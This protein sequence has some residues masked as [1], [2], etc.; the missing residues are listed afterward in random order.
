MA[1]P[2]CPSRYIIYLRLK[3]FASYKGGIFQGC[4]GDKKQEATDCQAVAAVGW[5]RHLIDA[6]VSPPAVAGFAE[7]EAL[8]LFAA[9]EAAFLRNWPYA[10]ALLQQ[11]DSSVRGHVGVVPLVGA[12]GQR[13][14]GTLGS[15]GLTL[16]PDGD[17]HLQVLGQSEVE[18]FDQGFNYLS[19]SCIVD[20]RSTHWQ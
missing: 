10:Y 17:V 14:G 5:L 2:L 6:G 7:N 15:W 18:L 12:P 4:A 11:S 20:S 13:G 19:F 3:A 8:Q 9:G 16:P 1:D